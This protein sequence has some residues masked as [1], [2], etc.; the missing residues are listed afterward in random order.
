MSLAVSDQAAGT[1][2]ISLTGSDFSVTL[3]GSTDADNSTAL[4]LVGTTSAASVGGAVVDTCDVCDG[5]GTSCVVDVWILQHVTITLE[6]VFQ[7][8]A[9]L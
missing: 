5:D 1:G 2:S 4:T 6:L 8:T 9:L 3:D 7:V